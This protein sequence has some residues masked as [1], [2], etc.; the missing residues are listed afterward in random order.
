MRTRRRFS[1]VSK[2]VSLSIFVD[3]NGKAI[4]DNF[5]DDTTAGGSRPFLMPDPTTDGWALL[6]SDGGPL[7]AGD[8]TPLLIAGEWLCLFG[9]AMP[10][11]SIKGVY[12]RIA[13][14]VE[15]MP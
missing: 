1:S 6:A 7:L 11:E 14:S 8:G 9:Q 3:R 12:F 2:P 13:F 10:S 15:V 4:F 5:Y